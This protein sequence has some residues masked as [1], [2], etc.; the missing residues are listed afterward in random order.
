MSTTST[1]TPGNTVIDD[2]AEQIS[3]GNARASDE[4]CQQLGM[5]VG[6]LTTW[7]TRAVELFKKGSDPREVSKLPPAFQIA[8]LKL[9][10]GEGQTD[11]VVDL[12]AMSADKEVK[13]EARRILHKLRSR[14]LSIDIPKES[15]PS[16]LERKVFEEPEL[17]CYFS[18][19]D[20]AGNRTLL[21]TRYAHGGVEVFHAE[22]NDTDGLTQFNAGKLGRHRYRELIRDLLD[23]HAGHLML[24][25]SYGEGRHH[26]A[27]A[28]AVARER[29]RPLPDG[30]LEASA[31]LGAPSAMDIP[32][33]PLVLF[34]PEAS[35]GQDA[36][37][38]A[39]AELIDLPEFGNW[40]PEEAVLQ[41]LQ[42]K[43]QEAAMSQLAINEQ[44]KIEQIERVI[45][46]APAVVLEGKNERTAYQ[47]RLLEMAVCFQRKGRTEQAQQI[48][49]VAWQLTTEGFQPNDSPFFSR[50]TKKIFHD[51]AEIVKSFGNQ[52]NAETKP[53]ADQGN[54]IVT[55]S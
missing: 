29:N 35:V 7:L 18:P 36:L 46:N 48:A 24:E 19:P 41:K 23:E 51:P 14:G 47:R 16:V 42:A 28:V 21:L 11:L 6:E 40:F 15:G 39:S 52:K 1:T 8:V 3:S 33:D 45:G 25:I 27:R 43:L 55:P 38:K 49:A 44:Q 31:T 30:Y 22:L 2:L 9:A 13:K 4:L 50:M 26:L 32:P 5:P 20:G 54:L 10:E 17:P 34:P 37:V 53:A 12:L